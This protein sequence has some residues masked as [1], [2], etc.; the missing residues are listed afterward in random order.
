MSEQFE[1][2]QTSKTLLLRIK[3]ASKRSDHDD[4][5]REFAAVYQPFVKAWCRKRRLSEFDAEDV[6]N[7]ILIKVW[8]A[9][10]TFEYEPAKG[11]FRRWLAVVGKNAINDFLK[12]ESRNPA[13]GSGDTEVQALLGNQAAESFSQQLQE[14]CQIAALCEIEDV[15]R[16]EVNPV[17]WQ[18]YWQRTYEGK[19]TREVAAQLGLTVSN[20][21]K[22]V[23]E[24]KTK[25]RQQAKLRED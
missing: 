24:V 17:A 15:V 8:R 18:C 23:W 16:A 22:K 3:A 25:L 10:Q 9:I 4:A 11:G 6:S 21:D 2:A 1:G 19:S 7:R 5:W 13:R 20:V 12:E 14:F